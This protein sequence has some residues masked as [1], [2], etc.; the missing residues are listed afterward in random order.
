MTG[1]YLK[2]LCVSTVG[3]I[4]TLT[5]FFWDCT[6]TKE[7][8]HKCFEILKL[9]D[10]LANIINKLNFLFGVGN[11]RLDNLSLIIKYHIYNLRK[12]RCTFDKEIFIKEVALRVSADRLNL[13]KNAF[14]LKWRGLEG[15]TSGI[16]QYL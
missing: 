12:N 13:N 14:A 5:H 4:D 6:Y 3:E 15:L 1:K 16:E 7:I 8:I 9:E 10:E 11:I 2:Q